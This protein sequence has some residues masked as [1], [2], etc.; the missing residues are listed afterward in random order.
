MWDFSWLERR[1]PGAGYESWERALDELAERGYDAVRIDVYPHFHAAGAHREYTI[2]P[3]WNQQMWGSPAKNRVTVQ[4]NLNQFLYLCKQRDIR[5]ALSSWYQNDQAEHRLTIAN[6]QT[7]ARQ[8]ISVLDAI[9][10]EDLLDTVLYVDLC[11]EWPVTTWTP[12]FQ[13]DPADRHF[14]SPTSLAWMKDAI[15]TVRVRYPDLDYCF[16]FTGALPPAFNPVDRL[17]GL[18][19]LFEP[20]IWMAQCNDCEFRRRIGYN[21]ELFDDSGY[22]N[23]VNRAEPLYRADPAYWQGLLRHSIHSY[24]DWSIKAKLPLITTE[25]WGVVD[26]KDWPLLNWDWVKQLCELGVNTA[27]LTGRWAAIATSNFCGPQF[28]GMWRDIDWHRRLTK[29]IHEAPLPQEVR[30]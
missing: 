12:F 20:H 23:I 16:S 24:A 27:A 29:I 3:C 5:V 26:Y 9:D 10:A 25:C 13:C 4:P 14:A 8:W 7:Q 19:G 11:N 15:E 21:H 28:V 6:A 1:W 22:R 30:A 2:I 18:F 17:H